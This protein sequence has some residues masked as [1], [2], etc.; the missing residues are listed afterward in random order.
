MKHLN[1]FS[2]LFFYFEVNVIYSN[3]G[4]EFAQC[5]SFKCDNIRTSPQGGVTTT[6]ADCR[7]PLGEDVFSALPAK[8][9]TSFVT[10]AGAS[11]S[12]PSSACTLNP[13][14]GF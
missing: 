4:R 9:A 7:C 12:N 14:G 3:Q 6:V 8:S 5:F 13:V 11:W 10:G 2:D 1:Y